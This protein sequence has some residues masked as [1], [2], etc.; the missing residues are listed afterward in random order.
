MAE[1]DFVIPG[2]SLG[3]LNQIYPG[4][5]DLL[6]RSLKRYP[7]DRISWED[8]FN[9]PWVD[10]RSRFVFL[11]FLELRKKKLCSIFTLSNLNFVGR[12]WSFV[13]VIFFVCC[14]LNLVYC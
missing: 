4:V 9:H 5:S 8:F 11:F 10:L 6:V 14:S 7:K 1:G 2:E 12:I 3:V 13:M